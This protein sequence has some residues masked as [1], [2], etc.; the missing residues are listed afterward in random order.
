MAKKNTLNDLNN[1]L[2]HQ[3]ETVQDK[4]SVSHQEYLA[5]D[6]HQ[7]TPIDLLEDQDEMNQRIQFIAAQIL[8]LAQENE[9]SFSTAF[10]K[11]IINILEHKKDLSSAEV[12]LLNTALFLDH[13]ELMLEGYKS[14][15][16]K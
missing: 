3:T 14:M 8:Q 2:K 9:Q 4:S 10:N 1:F 7:L 16:R 6:P 5:T 15:V 13:N 11:V 12:M